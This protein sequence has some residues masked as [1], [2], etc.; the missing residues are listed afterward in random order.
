MANTE[1]GAP[2]LDPVAKAYQ[3]VRDAT[4]GSSISNAEKVAV[5]DLVRHELLERMSAQIRSGVSL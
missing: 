2:A 4:L 5:L 3:V 1:K